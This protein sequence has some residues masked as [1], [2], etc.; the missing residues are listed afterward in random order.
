MS[1][2]EI[3]SVVI[4]GIGLLFAGYQLRQVAVSH[5]A[6]A[7]AN[8]TASLM[9]VLSIEDSLAGARARFAQISGEVS[10]ELSPEAAE[11]HQ[12]LLDEAKEQYLNVADRL[13]ACIRRGLIDEATHRQDYR[14][15]V[16][17]VVENYSQDLGPATRHPNILRVHEAWR[18]DKSALLTPKKK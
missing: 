16:N 9:A 8:R 13:C 4:A 15:W 5:L 14:F 12:A 7:E 6:V 18:E 11:R 2:F 1:A 17:E 3:V 10:S